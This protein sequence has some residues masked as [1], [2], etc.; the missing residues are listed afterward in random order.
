M[1]M[2]LE[3]RSTGFTAKALRPRRFVPL[4][5]RPRGYFW[6]YDCLSGLPTASKIFLTKLLRFCIFM[7]LILGGCCVPP[8]S[9]WAEI[10]S[11]AM[12]LRFI[13]WVDPHSLVGC[14]TPCHHS[15]PIL[16]QIQLNYYYSSAFTVIRVFG[17]GMA[18]SQEFRYQNVTIIWSQVVVIAYINFTTQDWYLNKIVRSM[19]NPLE[20]KRGFNDICG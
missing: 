17:K 19:Y 10:T 5:W 8:L 12:Q 13:C 20:F 2:R 4:S 6:G 14:Y 1:E 7:P 3:G 18:Q 11:L 15:I 16:H 9:Q